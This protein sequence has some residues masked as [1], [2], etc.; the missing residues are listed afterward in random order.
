MSTE[1]TNGE[2]GATTR[3]ALF[4]G[5]GALGAGALLA[6]CGTDGQSADPTPTPP[7]PTPEDSDQPDQNEPEEQEEEQDEPAQGALAEV[8]EVQVGGGVINTSER[9]VIT[10]PAEGDFRAF[11]AICT[12][13]GCTVS[14]V[15]D[16]E[17]VCRCHGSRY[18]IEDGSVL[19]SAPELTPQTQD[20]LAP[21][22]VTVDGSA[23]VRS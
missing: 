1:P 4:A 16:R 10:Q 20:P 2:T 21:V 18:S 22:D 14:E 15:V 17:I 6:A 12:H 13:Q 5:A 8:G 3:R 9:V 19:A 11:S 7:A 23:V